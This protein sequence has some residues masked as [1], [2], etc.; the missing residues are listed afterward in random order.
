VT[1]DSRQSQ[2]QPDDDALFLGRHSNELY[3]TLRGLPWAERLKAD[4]RFG[5]IRTLNTVQSGQVKRLKA[6]TSA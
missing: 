6:D 5:P 4:T 3:D 2:P 1:G